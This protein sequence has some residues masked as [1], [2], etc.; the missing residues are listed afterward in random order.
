MVRRLVEK[1]SGYFTVRLTVSR[2]PPLYGQLFVIFFG[3]FLTLYYD[4]MCS[5]TNSTQEKSI[6]TQLLESPIPPL[7]AA[8]LRMIIC[9]RLPSF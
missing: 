3:V 6:S 2:A 9:K 4:N 1:K 5:E 8:A 7:N